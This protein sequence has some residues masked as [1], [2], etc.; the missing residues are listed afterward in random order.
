MRQRN[1]V[2]KYAQRSGAGKHKIKGKDMKE[3]AYDDWND[4]DQQ[5]IT[6]ED[7]Y[8]EI[9]Y[10]EDRVEHL[11]QQVKDLCDDEVFIL[12]E[13][14]MV[15]DHYSDYKDIHTELTAIIDFHSKEV[16]HRAIEKLLAQY[17]NRHWG[18]F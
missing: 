16:K 10:L 7:H 3:K 12:S 11:E 15:R 8:S 17:P 14:M 18:P 4:A 5:V 1:Y 13:I 6:T 9:Q 2:A